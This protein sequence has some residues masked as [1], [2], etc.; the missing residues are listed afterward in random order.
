MDDEVTGHAMTEIALAL[1]MAFF[2]L[3]VLTLVSMGRGS[4]PTDEIGSSFSTLRVAAPGHSAVELSVTAQDRLVLAADGRYFD[5]NGQLID[6]SD[7]DTDARLLLA[8]DPETSLVELLRI[9]AAFSGQD[10]RLTPLNAAWRAR[11]GH[12]SSKIQSPKSPEIVR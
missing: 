12:L 2:C 8:I 5:P 11:L 3:L 7:I 1:A 9:R 10:V 6:P 4:A